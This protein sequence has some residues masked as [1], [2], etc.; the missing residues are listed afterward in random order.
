MPVK[1]WLGLGGNA[2]DSRRLLAEALKRL[3]ATPGVEVLRASRS[4]R[5]APWGMTEQ[6]DFVNAVAELESDLQPEELLGILQQVE[7]ALGRKRSG[8][9]WGPRN[10]DLDL[11]SCDGLERHTD[12]LQLPHPRMHLRAFV[13]VPL[14][15]LEPSFQIPGLGSAEACLERLQPAEIESVIPLQENDAED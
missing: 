15:E 3:Q 10:I 1:A 7:Q 14:L 4:Y 6:P 8:K 2:R 5:S 13:L 12:R 11:L 9:R